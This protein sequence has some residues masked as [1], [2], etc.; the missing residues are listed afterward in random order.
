MKQTKIFR[1]QTQC[2]IDELINDW[3]LDENIE[4]ESFEIHDIKMVIDNE[5]DLIA[6]VIYEADELKLYK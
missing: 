1:E 3:I 5:R 2:D 6:L 4:N